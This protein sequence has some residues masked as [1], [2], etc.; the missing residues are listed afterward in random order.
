MTLSF[1]ALQR[2][3]T[4]TNIHNVSQPSHTIRNFLLDFLT[5]GI[6]KL[7]QHEHHKHKKED[8]NRLTADLIKQLSNEPNRKH[9][10]V[11][12][13][14]ESVTVEEKAGQNGIDVYYQGKTFHIKELTLAQFVN[15][16][17]FDRVLNKSLYEPNSEINQILSERHSALHR[18]RKCSEDAADFMTSA[19]SNS[20]FNDMEIKDIDCCGWDMSGSHFVNTTIANVSFDTAKGP[21]PYKALAQIGFGIDNR[22]EYSAD[23]SSCQFVNVTA[24]HITLNKTNVDRAVI[25]NSK[26]TNLRLGK[27]DFSQT[28]ISDD[29]S[30]QLALPRKWTNDDLEQYLNNDV[31]SFSKIPPQHKHNLLNSID[32]IPNT[33]LKVDLI[34]QVLASLD[35]S[36]ISL[37]DYNKSFAV[38]LKADYRGDT[39]IQEFLQRHKFLPAVTAQQNP[40]IIDGGARNINPVVQLE[41]RLTAFRNADD[42][43]RYACD[44][45]AKSLLS[46]RFNDIPTEAVT[47]VTSPD[48][49]KLPANYLQVNNTMIGIASQYPKPDNLASYFKML[50]KEQP[51]VLLILASDKDIH[52]SKL[53]AYFRQDD[54]YGNV[55]VSSSK[56]GKQTLHGIDVNRYQLTVA[57][58]DQTHII[59]VIHVATWPD[60]AAVT[61]EQT[62]KL[63]EYVANV[64][65][66]GLN[67]NPIVAH[68]RAGVGRTGQFFA[69]QE[70]MKESL[71]PEDQRRSLEVIIKDLRTS[72]NHVMVQTP[73]QRKALCDLAN[74]L[75]VPIL[76]K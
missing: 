50:L 12:F 31:F 70:V 71:K 29:V 43:N 22:P 4:D 23:L 3:L 32:T 30:M 14:K 48:G 42:K 25:E 68:C 60:H 47:L 40:A 56:T 62:Q 18:D 55:Q 38:L 61:A 65:A 27:M 37:S 72:R 17:E 13:G 49:V 73:E 20:H 54:Q 15:R 39:Q 16:L 46:A 26:F 74:R 1:S 67:N 69:A 5:L 9:I 57:D 53:P 51:P 41:Q 7:Y 45:S 33:N 6:H 11:N 36:E 21:E 19:W 24:D 76:S 59:P 44:E 52:Q 58:G 34:R 10:T 28:K 66:E 75:G 63:V 35:Q 64:Q 8:F 2:S